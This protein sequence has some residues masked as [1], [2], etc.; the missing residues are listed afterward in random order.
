MLRDYFHTHFHLNSVTFALQSS[1]TQFLQYSGHALAHLSLSAFLLINEQVCRIEWLWKG[2]FCCGS[3]LWFC[4]CEAHV[5]HAE[6]TQE[7]VLMFTVQS[8]PGLFP[9]YYCS[10]KETPSWEQVRHCSESAAPFLSTHTHTHTVSRSSEPIKQ[11]QRECQQSRHWPQT[12]LALLA[13]VAHHLHI[14]LSSSETTDSEANYY[15]MGTYGNNDHYNRISITLR[16]TL[17]Q[18]G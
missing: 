9:V 10:R 6:E 18:M 11:Q 17:K 4:Q 3:A 13:S 12:G 15:N 8:L 14:L 16:Q 1:S 7:C 5:D 2:F